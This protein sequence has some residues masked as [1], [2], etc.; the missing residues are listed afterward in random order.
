MKYCTRCK[1]LFGALET[2][3]C[4]KCSKKLITEPNHY[5]PV[6]VVMA[7]GF[8]L[9]RIKAALKNSEIPFTVSEA[10]KDAGIQILNSAPPENCRV[11]VPLSFYNQACELLIGIGALGD[12]EEISAEEQD[13]LEQKRQADEEKSLSPQ[14]RFFSRLVFI[15]LFIAVVAGVVVITDLLIPFLNP[16][17]H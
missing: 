13:M 9:E 15:I 14:K 11:F 8:E 2:D 12:A 3:D 1:K 16:Y 7:N 6:E 4:P 10:V 5:S 17:Y